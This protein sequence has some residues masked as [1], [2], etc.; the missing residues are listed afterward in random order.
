MELDKEIFKKFFPRLFDEI[1]RKN[2]SIPITVGQSDHDAK[3]PSSKNFAGYVPD[4]VDFIRRCDTEQQAKRIIKYLVEK[5]EISHED[6]QR[7]QNQLEEKGVRSFGLKKEEDY[8]VKKGG[9]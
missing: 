6:A 1:K 5:G 2:H 4:V 3:E 8:Y 9:I 7:L